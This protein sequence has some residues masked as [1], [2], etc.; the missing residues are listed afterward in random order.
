VTF[1]SNDHTKPNTNY[2]ILTTL[3]LTLT[4]LLKAF[5]CRYFVT[6]YELFG[7]YVGPLDTL[8]VFCHADN[9]VKLTTNCIQFQLRL[10][11]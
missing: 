2:K 1:L 3:T 9:F 10:S 8:Q 6:L 4:T 5:V 11:V 7:T